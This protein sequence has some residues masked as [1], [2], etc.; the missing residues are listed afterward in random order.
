MYRRFFALEWA[1]G[2][3]WQRRRVQ[4]LTVPCFRSLSPTGAYRHP[5]SG[6]VHGPLEHMAKKCPWAALMSGATGDQ[7]WWMN[8]R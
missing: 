1:R 7:R 2:L 6:A 4:T 5:C 8:E 3:S